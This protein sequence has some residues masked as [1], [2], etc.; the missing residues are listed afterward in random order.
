MRVNST[1]L[2]SQL[3]D[4][5]MANSMQSTRTS[6]E[7]KIN[8][9]KSLICWSYAE[10][11]SRSDTT[12]ISTICTA[13]KNTSK[14]EPFRTIMKEKNNQECLQ[15]L[16]VAIMK[17][18]TRS[19]NL[20]SEVG[21]LLASTSWGKLDLFLWERAAKRSELRDLQGFTTILTSSTALEWSDTLCG[22]KTES[23]H[24]ILSKSMP[25]GWSS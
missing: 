5:C 4:V 19:G 9:R 22:E 21:W 11:S 12:P 18:S 3:K 10:T 6:P 8:S 20:T 2:R 23:Q 16:S 7:S 14:W 15:Y 25:F 17:P 24:T 1:L 13:L